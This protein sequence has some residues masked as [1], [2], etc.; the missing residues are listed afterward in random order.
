MDKTGFYERK[1]HFWQWD[2]DAFTFLIGDTN[3]IVS[4][5]ALWITPIVRLSYRM[6]ER[7]K[8]SD[9]PIEEFIALRK[10]AKILLIRSKV[11]GGA[12]FLEY[13]KEREEK[14]DFLMLW[15]SKGIKVPDFYEEVINGKE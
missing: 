11:M 10:E 3:E 8:I 4:H 1:D 14:L 15:T 13:M 9:N 5:V 12:A 7:R 6:V 2:T